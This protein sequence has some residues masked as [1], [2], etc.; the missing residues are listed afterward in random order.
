[1]KAIIIS[2]SDARALLDSLELTKMRHI[3]LMRPS[4]EE[5]TSYADVHRA[6]HY[7][8]TGWLQAQGADVTKR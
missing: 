5:S 2:D 4:T 3:D 1:M 7:I 8:V 6:F